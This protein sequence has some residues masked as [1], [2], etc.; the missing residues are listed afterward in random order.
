MDK[1]KVVTV[2]ASLR[3]F[4]LFRP[5]PLMAE[6]ESSGEEPS[7][8]RE[9]VLEAA[10]PRQEMSLFSFLQI[11]YSPILHISIFINWISLGLQEEHSGYPLVS[12]TSRRCVAPV[13]RRIYS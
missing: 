6:I 3:L 11:S 13:G 9:G 5:V 8:I 4:K 12:S 2:E 7:G 10:S 1:N